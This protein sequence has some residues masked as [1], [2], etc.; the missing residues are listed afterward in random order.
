MPRVM[1]KDRCEFVDLPVRT[2]RLQSATPPK[3]AAETTRLKEGISTYAAVGPSGA[4][5]NPACHSRRKSAPVNLDN[6]CDREVGGGGPDSVPAAVTA[7]P[8]APSSADEVRPASVGDKGRG[9]SAVAGG[10]APPVDAADAVAAASRRRV[11]RPMLRI[12]L[13]SNPPA[14][15]PPLAVPAPAPPGAA[16]PP[17]AAAPP[18]P[19]S[20]EPANADAA[21]DCSSASSGVT[22]VPLLNLARV[23][24]SSPKM[25][26]PKRPR[27]W[28]S[29][30]G[31]R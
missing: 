2:E 14:N 18:P 27:R 16:P 23:R 11:A 9:A 17:P 1:R 31:R 4:P 19:P 13:A 7:A 25:E 21:T 30:R 12:I 5:V 22:A 26:A 6:D 3:S 28:Y 29:R 20:I 8:V 24:A 15:P 10:T